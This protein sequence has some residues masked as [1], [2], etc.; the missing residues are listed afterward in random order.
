M[1]DSRVLKSNPEEAVGE[2][3]EEDE[4]ETAA[5][6][7]GFRGCNRNLK[8]SWNE[9]IGV[10]PNDETANEIIILQKSLKKISIFNKPRIR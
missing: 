1:A 8:C 2:E 5:W 4:G 10:F 3:E 6:I 7:W 9:A